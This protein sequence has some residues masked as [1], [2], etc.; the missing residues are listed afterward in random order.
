M[1]NMTNTN[2]VTIL[3][4]PINQKRLKGKSPFYVARITT[5]KREV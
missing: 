4:F 3:Y 1:E 5:I 2:D